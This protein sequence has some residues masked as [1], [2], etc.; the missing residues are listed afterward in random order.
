MAGITVNE[1]LS[2]FGNILYKGA[3]QE[4][5]T[6]GLFTNAAGSLT[7]TSTW[8]NVTQPSGTGY[9]EISLS[10]GTFVVDAN[11]T[12][13]YPQQQWTAGADWTGGDVQGYYIR[14]NNASPVLCHVQERDDGGFAM[15]NGRIYTVDLSVDSS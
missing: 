12:V 13:T 14:N 4:D 15:T 8:S 1:G 10:Q 9:A 11:G 3:T 7:E 5:L 2:Y 6:I